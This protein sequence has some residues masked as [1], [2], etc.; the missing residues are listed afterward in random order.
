MTLKP[1]LD[2][3]NIDANIGKIFKSTANMQPVPIKVSVAMQ[4]IVATADVIA[5]LFHCTWR[6]YEHE[7]TRSSL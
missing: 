1:N 4:L 6:F 5:N 3:F 7:A 2:F